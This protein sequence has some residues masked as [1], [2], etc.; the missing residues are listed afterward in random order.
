[1]C[2]RFHPHILFA[3]DAYIL[4][5]LDQKDMRMQ[6]NE[7]MAKNKREIDKHHFSPKQ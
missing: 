4:L 5:L 3:L 2:V 7:R 1:M 6:R